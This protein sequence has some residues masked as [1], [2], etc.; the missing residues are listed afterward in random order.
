MK[1]KP[2]KRRLFDPSIQINVPEVLLYNIL[3]KKCIIF[4]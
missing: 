2:I 4:T 3:E 1:P